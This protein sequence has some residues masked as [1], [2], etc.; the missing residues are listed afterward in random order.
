MQ[1]P[2]FMPATDWMAEFDH[3]PIDF[4]EQLSD[5]PLA[6]KGAIDAAIWTRQLPT[7]LTDWMESIDAAT[8]PEGRYIL[9][10][11][12]VSTCVAGLFAERG[13]AATPALTWLSEDA[14]NLA[15]YVREI[16]GT[17]WVRLRLEKIDDNAC[18][19]LH[20]DNVVA[21]MICTYHGPGTQLGLE[22][23][24]PKQIATVPTGMP[25]LL[26]GRQWPDVR[27]T[28]L[29]H[30]SPPVEGTNITRLVLVL[31]GAS[32]EDIMPAYDTL[33]E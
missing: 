4:T 25:L 27:E 23:C 3:L 7:G 29:R 6:I 14:A 12:D 21:R 10:P 9:T 26:K 31:E 28:K 17:E 8:L 2:T 22:E 15:H 19:K 5:W 11:D 16:A 13:L 18:S 32:S 33:Y 24:A 1:Q 30:R 20:V